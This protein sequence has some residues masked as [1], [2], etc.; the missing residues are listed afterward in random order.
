MSRGWKQ[1]PLLSKDFY[2]QEVAACQILTL[3]NV[4]Q[5][6]DVSFVSETTPM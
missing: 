2:K 4:M 1:A 6:V 5:E 3:Y